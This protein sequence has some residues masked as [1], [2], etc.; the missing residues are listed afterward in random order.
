MNEDEQYRSMQLVAIVFITA[1]I[2][3]GIILGII[4]GTLITIL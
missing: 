3:A 1:G 4:L 2:I